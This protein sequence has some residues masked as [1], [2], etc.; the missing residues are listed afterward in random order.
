MQPTHTPPL[1]WI[2][3]VDLTAIILAAALLLV[4]SAITRP[5]HAVAALLIAVVLGA[6]LERRG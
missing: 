1:S 4:C 3:R 5:A 6:R 2:S